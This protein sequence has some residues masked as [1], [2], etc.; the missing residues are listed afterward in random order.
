MPERQDSAPETSASERLAKSTSRRGFLSRLGKALL[1]AAGGG[2]VAAALDPEESS[3]YHFCGHTYTTGS[4][5]H[6]TGLPRIDARGLPLR[7]KDGVPI[8]NLGRPIDDEGRPLDEDGRLLRDLE[9]R[10]LPPA[11]RTPVCKEVER[12]FG[13]NTQIDGSWY[14]CCGG[15]VRKLMDCCSY[16]NHRINGDASLT[17]YCYE[18]RKVFCVM[19]HQTTVPC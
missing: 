6:P 4:C 15:R 5:P 8:D 11:P 14:R 9:G 16:S 3:A 2:T 7:A 19:Y 18:G 13:F 17:G 10:P 1:L 12:R